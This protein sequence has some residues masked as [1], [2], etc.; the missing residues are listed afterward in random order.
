ME[1]LKSRENM[2]IYDLLMYVR[3]VNSHNAFA[4]RPW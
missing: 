4:A 2:Y 1:P 3:G